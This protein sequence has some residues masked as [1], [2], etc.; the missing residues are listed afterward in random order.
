MVVAV[1]SRAAGQRIYIIISC[2]SYA[3]YLYVKQVQVC[4]LMTGP[5]LKLNASR[6]DACGHSQRQQSLQKC[7]LRP[8]TSL[9]LTWTTFRWTTALPVAL[10]RLSRCQKHLQETHSSWL[11]RP[12]YR[13]PQFVSATNT[14]LL[15]VVL[16][17]EGH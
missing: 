3:S 15:C 2:I 9:R 6:R 13:A 11:E 14:A 4:K 8:S 10:C 1:A 17:R 7:L 5:N 16:R 12:L